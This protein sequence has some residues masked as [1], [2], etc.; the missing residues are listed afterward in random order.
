MLIAVLL[1][2]IKQSHMHK[3]KT[4]ELKSSSR[5]ILHEE[6]YSEPER[7]LFQ[8]PAPESFMRMNEQ[9]EFNCSVCHVQEENGH[10][11]HP[12]SGKGLKRRRSENWTYCVHVFA[13]L[14]NVSLIDSAG[15]HAHVNARNPD[16]TKA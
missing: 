14:I 1:V 8:K 4:K 16:C 3:G 11:R 10:G 13:R 15:E 2:T 9:S 5:K 12:T 6:G 7:S